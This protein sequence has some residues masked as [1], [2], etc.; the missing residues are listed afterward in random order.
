[1]MTST[2]TLFMTQAATIVDEEASMIGRTQAG[3]VQAFNMLVE[4]YQNRVYAVCYRMLGES[5]AA[6]ATQEVFLS[7]F[8]GIRHYH[9]GS[10]LAWI[11]RIAKNKCY[12]YL[13]IRSRQPQT[14]LDPDDGSS[15]LLR[16]TDPNEAPDD[17]VLRAELA[18]KINHQ[19]QQLPADQRLVVILSDV[20]E[21]SYD[22][23]ATAT[24]WPVGTVKSRLSRGR[25]RLRNALRGSDDQDEHVEK[26]EE[27]RVSQALVQV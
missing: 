26:V 1:M 22:E 24:G 5:D 8:R 17:R 3:D 19:I 13:R 10:F 20:E 18:R 27:R 9:G 14:L 21:Y 15:V 7:A 11:L 16:V 23:I 25:A 4:R 12:D 6:D 2:L